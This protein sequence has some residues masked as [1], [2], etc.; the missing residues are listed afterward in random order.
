[1]YV[2]ESVLFIYL[3]R[4]HAEIVMLIFSGQEF[5]WGGNAVLISLIQTNGVQQNIRSHIT[6]KKKS[7]S[8][9]DQYLPYYTVLAGQIEG[10]ALSNL[11]HLTD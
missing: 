5:C 1:V 2:G 3:D 10:L 9:N 11:I 4:N 7:D 8:A 6:A